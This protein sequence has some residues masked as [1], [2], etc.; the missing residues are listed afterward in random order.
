MK[1]E[2]LS[3][4]LA[5]IVVD[6]RRA[7]RRLGPRRITAIDAVLPDSSY[8]LQELLSAVQ[9]LEQDENSPEAFMRQSAFM[10]AAELA[11]LGAEAKKHL[12]K[13]EPRHLDA[14][15]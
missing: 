13:T 8:A 4:G 11:T 15:V 2:Q 7:A 3:R 5:S 12:L 10:L 1:I 9:N 6:K 14:T